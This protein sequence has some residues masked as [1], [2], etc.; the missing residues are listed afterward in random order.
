MTEETRVGRQ[1]HTF[2]YLLLPDH[3]NL[4]IKTATVFFRSMTKKFD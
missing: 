3:D 4:K 2:K 1:V